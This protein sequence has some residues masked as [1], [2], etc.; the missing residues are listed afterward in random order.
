MGAW[1]SIAPHLMET[2]GK[3]VYYLGRDRSASPATG[4]KHL[5]DKEQSAILRQALE[6]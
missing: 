3:P 5:H 1:R 6:F 4:S 2:T